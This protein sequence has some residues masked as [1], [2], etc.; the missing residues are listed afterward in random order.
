MCPIHCSIIGCTESWAAQSDRHKCVCHGVC[1]DT[2]SMINGMAW[3]D[4]HWWWRLRLTQAATLHHPHPSPRKP[5]NRWLPVCFSYPGI[6]SMSASRV[7]EDEEAEGMGVWGGVGK[8]QPERSFV[9]LFLCLGW[10]TLWP[11]LSFR[12]FFIFL[13]WEVRRRMRQV[14]KGDV[15]RK[16][17]KLFFVLLVKLVSS[18]E[19]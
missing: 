18:A 3:F 16:G 5:L 2:S 15:E 10:M 9:E 4:P 17:G 19:A 11:L 7:E 8:P 13:H 1:S 14:E 6:V 12:I